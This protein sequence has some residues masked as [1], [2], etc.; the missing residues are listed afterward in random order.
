MS[1]VNTFN[2]HSEHFGENDLKFIPVTKT[3]RYFPRLC[4]HTFN[5]DWLDE[6]GTTWK[7][8]K[9]RHH[10][11]EDKVLQSNRYAKSLID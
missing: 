9:S 7:Q 6:T 4:A 11:T 10:F 5:H 1:G 2:Q 3:R 8:K